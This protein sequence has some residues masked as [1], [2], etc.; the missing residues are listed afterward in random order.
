MGMP[1][2]ELNEKIGCR[3][4]FTTMPVKV[5]SLVSDSVNVKILTSLMET[6]GFM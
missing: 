4:G 5:A 2:A 3:G 6:V 1:M